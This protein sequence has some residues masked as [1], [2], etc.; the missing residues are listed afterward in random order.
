MLELVRGECCQIDRKITAMTDQLPKL[1]FHPKC[2]QPRVSFLC[3]EVPQLG[4]RIIC[5]FASFRDGI[6]EALADQEFLTATSKPLHDVI[7]QRPM[8]KAGG[9]LLTN[10]MFP[11]QAC[12]AIWASARVSLCYSCRIRYRPLTR[13]LQFKTDWRGRVR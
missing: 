3:N 13:F 12:V 11:S 6:S 10:Y 4:M 5:G 8:T 9:Q 7:F 1:L 2:S